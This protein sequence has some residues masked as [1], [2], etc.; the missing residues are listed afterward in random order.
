MAARML[1]ETNKKK[2]VFRDATAEKLDRMRSRTEFTRSRVRIKFPCGFVM[3]A[4]FGALE[5]F[6]S[7]Y[8]FVRDNLND[9]IRSF[10]L[11]ESPPK[12]KLV[13]MSKTLDKAKMCPACLL[14]FS[15]ED[16]MAQNG[17]CLNLQHLKQFITAY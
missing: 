6:Q 12:R 10:D 11:F 3:E 15:W 5:N 17:P 2:S 4:N 7:V 1:I 8:N 13:E 16:D 14:Y 9:K